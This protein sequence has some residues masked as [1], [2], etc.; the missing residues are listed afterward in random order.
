MGNDAV[1]SQLHTNAS[2][3][4]TRGEARS[5]MRKY[6]K[7]TLFS[8]KKKS[9]F[10][11][12]TELISD[13]SLLLC[14]LV[15]CVA[16]CF[17]KLQ[18]AI[19]IWLILTASVIAS[20]VISLQISRQQEKRML[21][22]MPM[23]HVI[24]DGKLYVT[25]AWNLVPGDLILLQTGDIVPA[26]AR[27]IRSSELTVSTVVL[28]ENKI[29]REA[30]VEKTADPIQEEISLVPEYANM[31]YG[32][33]EI[34]SGEATAIVT[35][36]GSNTF[37]GASG[38]IA[39]PI[40]NATEP[41]ALAKVRRFCN[42]YGTFLLISVIPVTLIGMLFIENADFLE[43]FLL[44][45]SL[46]VSC[47]SGEIISF[48]KLV[49]FHS[50][51]DAAKSEQTGNTQVFL[52]AHAI[53]A[54]R[55]IDE[56][57][58]V[59][60]AALHDGKKHAIAVYAGGHI[61]TKEELGGEIA[62][63]L[64][65]TVYQF[66][67]GYFQ[68]PA[69]TG[70]SG[71]EEV[72]RCNYES[73]QQLLRLAGTDLDTL[74]MVS[75]TP[76]YTAPT[77]SEEG[78]GSVRITTNNGTFA[79]YLSTNAECIHRCTSYRIGQKIFPATA[80]SIATAISSTNTYLKKHCQILFAYT[81]DLSTG[82]TIFEGFI[83]LA[84]SLA[85]GVPELLRRFSQHHIRVTLFVDKA[86]DTQHY[87]AISGFTDQESGNSIPL[88]TRFIVADHPGEA[89]NIYNRELKKAGKQTLAFSVENG[90]LALIRNADIAV[91]CDPIS[92]DE[93]GFSD[94]FYTKLL[95]EGRPDSDRAG[96]L[97]RADSDILIRRSSGSYGGLHS[98]F[99][100][101]EISVSAS[102]HMK[103]MLRYLACSQFLRLALV[104]T[105]LFAGTPIVSSPIILMSG[106]VVDIFAI[107][108]IAYS[109]PSELPKPHPR[110]GM[111]YSVI[112]AVLTGIA[113]YF[114]SMI[115]EY[116]GR[117]DAY[118]G[119]GCYLFL[120]ILLTQICMFLVIYRI[121]CGKFR[122]NILTATILLFFCTFIV[123]G[124]TLDPIA[125]FMGIGGMNLFRCAYLW[126][127]PLLFLVLSLLLQIIFLRHRKP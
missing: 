7:N 55:H 63:P 68:S 8:V 122:I 25:A 53:D 57:I 97:V 76:F 31:V 91:S 5:R 38:Y 70:Q 82:E 116:I 99:A 119:Q 42:I 72:L 10:S 66:F 16:A 58:L 24:R 73:I 110:P 29:T 105:T 3:G 48:A 67:R 104:L 102:L 75:G 59:G 56:V 36:T 112:A 88:S 83:V 17:S 9:V 50:A 94:K 107:L 62:D 64:L 126:C 2:S 45:L 35:A 114:F 113:L 80:F 78:F 14:L 65:T 84:H 120:S 69:S 108:L 26:D 90:S 23:A 32:M 6:G 125:N 12:F 95:P 15:S 74:T 21:Y 118:S 13:P 61:C 22:S 30:P 71:F 60:S 85:T 124:I 18:T 79:H 123:R 127:A 121:F 52:N 100:A 49:Y 44:A 51:D 111:V 47:M 92:Y 81:Q 96:Q 89:A 43:L 40:A 115:P 1:I 101:F 103:V 109:R 41:K 11:C 27:I 20:T 117:E 86:L 77:D 87:A 39:D 93:D 46:A 19:I 37:L 33:S 34:L 106:L 54:V 28:N 98:I 4:L